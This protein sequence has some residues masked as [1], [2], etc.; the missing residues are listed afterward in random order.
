MGCD[1]LSPGDG[2]D[3]ED[4]TGNRCH[5]THAQKYPLPGVPYLTR[6]ENVGLAC[7]TH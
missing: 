6:L 2:L 3:V 7:L 1:V 5:M 4:A